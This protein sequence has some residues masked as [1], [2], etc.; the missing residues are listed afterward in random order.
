VLLIIREMMFG[1]HRFDQIA[2]NTGA[3]RDR[4]AAR[5]RGL[6]DS[7]LVERRPYSDH[8]RR[9]EYHLT[10][11]GRDLAPV[12]RALRRWGDKWTTEQPPLTVRHHCGHELD[13]VS[14]CGAC[15]EEIRET[16]LAFEAETAGWD[17]RGP[18]A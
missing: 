16:D 4:L 14:R 6:V 11:A 17:L 9:V 7:G 3:P 2:R 12:V 1:N 10:Q 5:L 8:P 13:V 18:V 15:G